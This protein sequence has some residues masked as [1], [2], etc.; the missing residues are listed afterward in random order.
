MTQHHGARQPE[1][2]EPLLRLWHIDLDAQGDRLDAREA[3]ERW[4]SQ[5]ERNA[6][7][8]PEALAPGRERTLRRRRARIALRILLSREGVI[9]ARGTPLPLRPGGKPAL[10]Y[11]NG[12]LDFSLSYSGS[13]CLVA[14]GTPA[15]IGVDLE[16]P[17][18][19]AINAN[20]R[21]LIVA[22]GCAL[23]P[24]K[25]LPRD[26]QTGFI[27]AWTR[28]E[29]FAKARG[30]GIGKLLETLGMTARGAATLTPVDANS[31]AAALL[32]D[33][34]LALTDIEVPTPGIAALAAPSEAVAVRS[35]CAPV[36][37]RAEF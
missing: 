22:A 10:P 13:H 31:R 5:S 32:A 11:E 9:A 26:D 1:S 15:P 23:V 34:G 14:I 4:L 35:P 12:T 17:R 19:V 7:A 24:R 25:P 16:R 37:F 33:S 20:R 18:D 30:D 21:A 36:D 2:R 6:E 29:A 28:L 3:S 27:A 8:S